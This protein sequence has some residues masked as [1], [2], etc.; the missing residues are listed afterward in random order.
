MLVLAARA[1]AVAVDLAA[2]WQ[3]EQLKPRLRW[4]SWRLPSIWPRKSVPTR[5]P[6]QAVQFSVMSGVRLKRWP[7]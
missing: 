7:E 2:V 6:W 1:A 4:V 5:L 3:L